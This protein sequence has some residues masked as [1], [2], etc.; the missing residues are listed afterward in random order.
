MKVAIPSSSNHEDAKMYERFGRC[1]Y[2]C[3]YDSE[4]DTYDFVSNPAVNARG[5]AGF[6]AVE[7][8]I[9]NE[10]NVVIVPRLGPNADGVLRR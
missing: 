7:F 1:N 10:V 9:N 6:Q 8:L 3:Y 2:F 4:K 5:G